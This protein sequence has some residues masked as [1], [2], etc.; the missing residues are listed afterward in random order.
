MVQKQE[1]N[2]IPRMTSDVGSLRAEA[3]YGKFRGLTSQKY[4]S[5]IQHP[6]FHLH[7]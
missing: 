6:F 1:M 5:A 4:C 3:R 2:E 7:Y